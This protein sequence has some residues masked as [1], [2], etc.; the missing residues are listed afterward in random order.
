MA[1]PSRGPKVAAIL[2]L[3]L[4]TVSPLMPISYFRRGRNPMGLYG[5]SVTGYLTAML[6]LT[7]L[8]WH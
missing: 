7:S 1:Q 2:F 6:A 5:G 8:V 3:V 4:L